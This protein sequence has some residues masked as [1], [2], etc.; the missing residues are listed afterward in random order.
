MNQYECN[1]EVILLNVNSARKHNNQASTSYTL[2]VVYIVT[3]K[4]P[5]ISLN[6]ILRQNLTDQ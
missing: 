6:W 1:P 2:Y 3:F 5:I 4:Y